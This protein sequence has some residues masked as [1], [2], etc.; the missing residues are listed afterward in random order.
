MKKAVIRAGQA[1]RLGLAGLLAGLLLCGCAAEPDAP[2]QADN[3]LGDRAA[4]AQTLY[5]W[6]EDGL[7]WALDWQSCVE[8]PLCALPDCA[9]RDASCPAYLGGQG[10]AGDARRLLCAAGRLLAVTND[11]E[12]AEV[13]ALD[14]AGRERTLLARCPLAADSAGLYLL[15]Y[16]GNSLWF[17]CGDALTLRRWDLAAQRWREQA[18]LPQPLQRLY[19]VRDGVLYFETWDYDSRTAALC[20]CDLTAWQAEGRLE[21]AELCRYDP[22]WQR[23]LLR[24]DTLYLADRRGGCAVYTKNLQDDAPLALRC[25]LPRLTEEHIVDF[26]DA[27]GDRAVLTWNQQQWAVDLAAGTMQ[28]IQPPALLPLYDLTDPEAPPQMVPFYPEIDLGTAAGDWTLCVGYYRAQDALTVDAAGGVL[29]AAG[30]QAVWCRLD[31]AAYLAGEMRLKEAE[32]GE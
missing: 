8:R 19:C 6:Q 17:A 22:D 24:E 7:V 12:A 23:I 29:S 10:T 11:G 14:P 1:A 27:A 4:T 9:H 15:W 20:R 32:K 26:S 21:S 30:K 28:R 2:L 5:R 3:W 18:D 31:R 16:D 25:R 13:Y